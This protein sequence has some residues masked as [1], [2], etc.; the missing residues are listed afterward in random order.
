MEYYIVEIQNITEISSE[1][2][3][4]YRKG[5]TKIFHQK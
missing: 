4:E 2:L 3:I 1:D 5:Y